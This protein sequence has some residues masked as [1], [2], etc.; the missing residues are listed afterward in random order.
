M[1]LKKK[2]KRQDSYQK[3][4][5]EAYELSLS[6]KDA[7]LVFLTEFVN[8][9]RPASWKKK[10]TAETN[11]HLVIADLEHSERLRRNLHIA[12]TAT[13]YHTNLLPALT[14]SGLLISRGFVQEFIV[15]LN[16]KFIPA[17]QEEGDFLYTINHI[18]YHK[19]DYA[20]VEAISRESWLQ[21]F[22]YFG[23]SIKLGDKILQNHLYEA[24][25]IL[26]YKVA[27]LGL[28]P[29]VGQYMP[30]TVFDN[31]FVKQNHKANLLQ[32]KKLE[33]QDNETLLQEF[34]ALTALLEAC[35]AC[36]DDIREIQS[37][38]G[39]SLSLTYSILVMYSSLERMV[40]LIDA[41]EGDHHFNTN[42]LIELFRMLVR[43]EKRKNSLRE[44]FSQSFGYVAYQIA[45]HKGA[46]GG[47]YIT[48]SPAEYYKMMLSAIWGGFIISFIA[49]FKSLLG[50]LHLPP[51]WQGVAYSINYSFGFLLI[52]ETH[53]TLATKQPA[54]TASAVAESLDTRKNEQPNL[55]NL[56]ITVA[57]VVR[58]QFASFFGNLVAVFPLTY[59]LAWGYDALFHHK[60]A[61][62][63]DAMKMLEDQHP[64]HSFSLL[65]ACNT[66]VF[67]FL[68]GLIAGFIQNKL[69]YSRI[70]DRLMQH[71]VLSSTTSPARLKRMAY[72][73]QNHL[74]SIAGNVSLGFFLGMSSILVKVFG[75]PF[76]IRHITIS[77]AN[78]GIATYGIG[79]QNLQW[80]YLLTVI[81]GVLGIGF[82]NFLVS[83]A[84][85]FIVAVKS[86][87]I[88]L[89]DY[90]EFL[91]ILWRYFKKYP[92]DFIRPRRKLH[93]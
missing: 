36:L 11:I 48:S 88:K 67:L 52:E 62:G 7:C 45:E 37:E 83:F 86:R 56:A 84:L 75:I 59:M 90:P 53:S 63:A 57:R 61:G 39:A 27:Q 50:W 17:L 70:A 21:L 9:I 40:L 23:I 74:G 34:R 22:S 44:L 73:L 32:L 87:G 78:V 12:V 82:F 42:K 66:G 65:Y 20:W 31:P 47:K 6:D 72:Y 28:D 26:S 13:L 38:K 8:H 92:L 29:V 16:H 64:W 51:F 85:A 41:V 10:E 55:Y 18:F 3:S 49:V 60:I 4:L 2:H 79:F 25:L 58:S 81:L 46:K 89:K 14:E 80:Q 30:S 68:S 69:Q 1:L 76:D 5:D 71:P 54:F 77:A 43:N 35:F 19:N 91:K 15:R 93:E 24:L 33:G